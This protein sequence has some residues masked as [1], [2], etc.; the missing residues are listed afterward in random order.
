MR[1]EGGIITGCDIFQFPN[2]SFAQCGRRRRA[3]DWPWDRFSALPVRKMDPTAVQQ[4]FL[5]GRRFSIP[6]VWAGGAV[7]SGASTS[8]SPAMPTNVNRAYRRA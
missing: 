7:R 1:P 6:A 2:E 4:D 3:K 5:A 8:S